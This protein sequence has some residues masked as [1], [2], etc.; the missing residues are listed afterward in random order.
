MLEDVCSAA[1]AAA[2]G[3]APSEGSARDADEER[4]IDVDGVKG[5]GG[6]NCAVACS[7]YT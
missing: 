1:P 7:V 5:F 4:G 6:A 2:N 3:V